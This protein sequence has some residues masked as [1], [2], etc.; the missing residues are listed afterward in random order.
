MIQFKSIEWSNLLST[1]NV[2]NRIQLDS[3]NTT[4]IIGKNG[5]GKSTVL[6]ALTFVLFGK[7]F[8]SISKNQLINSINGKNTKVSVEFD[9]NGSSYKVIRGIKPNIFEIYKN[10]E[11]LTQDAALKDYQLILEQQILKMNYRAFTQVVILG[12]SSFVPFMQLSTGN[13]R[14]VI[15]D[16]LDIR[17]FSTMNSLLKEKIQTTKRE[18]ELVDNTINR[19]KSEIESQKSIIKNLETSKNKHVD[20]I[21]TRIDSN[22][23][24]IND[25]N[26]SI[27]KIESEVDSLVMSISDANTITEVI[28]HAK[29]LLRTHT[30]NNDLLD[31]TIKFFDNNEN[32]PQCSQEIPHEHKFSIKDNLVLEYEMNK[33]EIESITSEI[34]S[35]VQRQ[36]EIEQIDNKIRQLRNEI[37]TYNSKLEI[38]TSQNISLQS[39]IDNLQLDKGDIDKEKLKLKELA[40]IAMENVKQKTSLQERRN[41]EDISSI[42]LKDTGIKSAVIREYLPVMNTLINKYLS[43]MDFY[44][45]FE[46]DETFSETI[47]SRHRDDFTYSSFSEGEKNRIDLALLFAW[48]E[49]AKLKNSANTNLLLLDE[50]LDGSLDVNGT[51]FI[52][53]LLT[54]LGDIC[55]VFVI[56]HNIDQIVDKF[57]RVL[58]VEKRNDFSVI[59]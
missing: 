34:T 20:S 22:I 26:E 10:E 51:D 50:V 24:E 52:I 18:L 6:D 56:S 49:I 55:N 42:L 35:Y 14:E 25:T 1:G 53:N 37:Y 58:T 11:L 45:K 4:L 46:L 19:S 41:I 33:S 8:R 40:N 28:S 36:K 54:Q 16:I 44:V 57:D 17:I 38:L 39:D 59:I 47:K 21:R 5:N 15:E 3:H 32:C 9:T 12:S 27:S 30:H 13:R 43:A 2:P 29:S 23:T 7:S 31:K 48:R